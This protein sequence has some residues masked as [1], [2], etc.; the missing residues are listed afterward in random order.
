[1]SEGAATFEFQ[2]AQAA[3]GTNI[4]LLWRPQSKAPP[5]G[6]G[7]LLDLMDKAAASCRTIE[8]LAQLLEMAGAAEDVD[9]A[10]ASDAGWMIGNHAKKLRQTLKTLKEGPRQ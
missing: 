1:M 8:V 3:R 5:F 9:G 6:R 2:T 10:L 7:F 4:S